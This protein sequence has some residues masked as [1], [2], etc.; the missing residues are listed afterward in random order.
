M[1]ITKAS[2]LSLEPDG[3]RKGYGVNIP[4]GDRSALSPGHSLCELFAAKSRPLPRE[5]YRELWKILR[6]IFS[7]RSPT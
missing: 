4:R 6:L 7:G 1:P 2:L 3:V 5:R